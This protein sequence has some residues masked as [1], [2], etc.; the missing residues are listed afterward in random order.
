MRL[1]KKVVAVLLSAAMLLTAGP[2]VPTN[3][4]R[5]SA[6]TKS[7]KNLNQAEITD[8]MGAGWNLGNQLEAA[9]SGT[10]GE[11]N[12]GNPVI[13]EDLI[14]AVKDAGFKSIRIPVSYLS[15]IGNDSNY[16]IQSSWLDRVQE[17]VD[18]CIDNDLYAIVNM[19]GDGYTSI[20]GGW[21]LC[22]NSNQS[23]IKA[24]YEACWKQI[25]DRFKDYDE[26]LIFES[27][28][29]E[30][31]GTYG[32]PNPTAYANINDYNQIFVDTVRKSGGNND[33]RW[34]LIPGWNTNIDYT[35][36]DYGFK[37][38][39]DNY[40]SDSISSDE[41]RIMISVHYYD[42]WDFCGTETG[43]VT[44][45]GDTVTDYSKVAGWGD[46]SYMISQ[47]KKM[48]DKFV[49]KGYPVV[50]G[51]YGS[52]DKS[53]YDSNNTANRKE[54]AYKVCYYS[55]QY[56]LIPVY[57]DNGYNGEY[58]FGL[59][60][61][62]SYKVT[63]PQIIDGI[64]EVYGGTVEATAT[65]I[66]LNQNKLTIGVGEGKKAIAATL[67]PAGCTDKITWKSSDE[68][69]ATVNS[70]GE[71]TAVSVGTCIIT[72]KTPNGHSAECEVT[73]PKPSKIK[74]KLYLLETANWQSV[75]SDESVDIDADGGDYSLTLKATDAQLKNIG[76]LYIRDISVG[77]EEA[78]AFDKATLK[79]DSFILNGKKYEMN[80]DTFTYDVQE[81]ASDDGLINPIFNFSFIN[82][83]A[84]TH[85]KDVTVESGNYK[86]Y[87]NNASYQTANTLTMNFSVTG[88]NGSAGEVTPTAEPTKAPTP[89]VEPTKEPI[90]TVEPTKEPTAE[91]TEVPTVKPT[92]TPVVQPTE[93]PVGP[94]T[95]KVLAE[96]STKYESNDASWL[97]DAEDS[98]VITLTYTCTEASHSGWGILG[99]GAS[100]NSNWTNGTSYN[101]ASNASEE[102]TVTCTA[103]ELKKSMNIQP[104]SNVSY[105][106]LSTWNGGKIIRLSIA[107][108]EAA[109]EPTPTVEP[110]KEPTPTVEPTTEPVPTVEPTEEPT[111][112]VAP[113]T[114]P[115][116][117]PS[118][119]GDE[120]SGTF[121][122]NSDWGS[123]GLGTIEIKNTTGRTFTDGWTV[124]FTVDREI[125]SMWSGEMVSLGNGRYQVS[126]PGWSKYLAAGDTIKLDFSVGSGSAT[127]SISDI[128][129]Y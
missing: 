125:T 75:I 61:R 126:N 13:M 89:T 128:T 34:L 70:K 63:Q 100:V 25:A 10:P 12:W 88:I 67:S 127:P 44:Q 68:N 43:A 57:W 123:G 64:M 124:E 27:M 85:V 72:A 19:H 107:N 116:T 113:T 78:S 87:F 69:I 29:E 86:A 98:D 74:A 39:S 36:G 5:V 84:N 105:I 90:P 91:P 80:Q 21:L 92:E 23:Q 53:N 47:F 9:N 76:S 95:E 111:P 24:K 40:L 73:V 71:V 42:P 66:S 112:T 118:G 96:N 65:G 33:K 110:T 49:A 59:F 31:D 115:T 37:L 83:W 60:D 45:W 82:V 51:E 38:P 46:E 7:F 114:E 3:G 79:V 117:P 119:E 58:G 15:M 50:I 41:K 26:H 48:H 120:V 54:F 108:K 14:L 56:G 22:G 129:I 122:M 11:T 28:N 93:T 18:F 97:T 52:I 20:S 62:Y 101:A 17:V 102:I 99:W 121:K 109:V 35:A 30:F 106:C 1:Q 104:G 77:D 55:E 8:A 16:T 6:A 103:A 81:E 32:T 94:L 4:S 2:M